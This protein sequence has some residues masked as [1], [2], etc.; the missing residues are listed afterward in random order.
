MNNN[1]IERKLFIEKVE[2]LKEKKRNL[3]NAFISL[4]CD[5]ITFDKD[6][7]NERIKQYEDDIET[8]LERIGKINALLEKEKEEK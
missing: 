1:K 8:L 6:V 5:S 7:L 2:F 3:E 4:S